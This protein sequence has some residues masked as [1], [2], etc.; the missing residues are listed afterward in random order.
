MSYF[1]TAKLHHHKDLFTEPCV[2]TSALIFPVGTLRFKIQTTESQTTLFSGF[3][4]PMIPKEEARNHQGGTQSVFYSLDTGTSNHHC[5][6]Q[7]TTQ[8]VM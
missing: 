8:T 1:K 5:Y 6:L 7:L 2:E 3:V 4:R